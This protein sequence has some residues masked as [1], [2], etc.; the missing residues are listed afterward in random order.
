[1]QVNFLSSL[2]DC[3]MKSVQNNILAVA[4]VPHNTG[5]NMNIYWFNMHHMAKHAISFHSPHYNVKMP[6]SN[7]SILESVFKKLHF[8]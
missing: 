2:K 5:I 8:R 3:D 6:F 4:I 1:M 7:L